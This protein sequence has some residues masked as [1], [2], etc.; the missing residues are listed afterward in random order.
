MP[1]ARGSTVGRRVSAMPDRT[2]RRRRGTPGER[3]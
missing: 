3:G 2:A 1:F